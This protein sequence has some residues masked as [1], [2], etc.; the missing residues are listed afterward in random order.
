VNLSL[1]VDLSRDTLAGVA[2]PDDEVAFY[3]HGKY[4]PYSA[5]G[6]AKAVAWGY[7][8]VYH[9]AGGFPEWEDAGYPVEV[10]PVR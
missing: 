3:C 10:G 6:S 1:V 9:F 7:R 8:R 2:G 4:C 5:F